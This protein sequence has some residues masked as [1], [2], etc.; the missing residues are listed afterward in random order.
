V[1]RENWQKFEGMRKFSAAQ[2]NA[3]ENTI[4]IE[5]DRHRHADLLGLRE[6]LRRGGEHGPFG[7]RIRVERS[8]ARVIH[9]ERKEIVQK[10]ESGATVT[11]G[12]E[13]VVTPDRDADA[14]TN[15]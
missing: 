15:G 1:T 13:I 6:V 11:S 12:D 5:Q 9:R 2:L 14:T 3:G 8:Y 7:G 10:L 4:T